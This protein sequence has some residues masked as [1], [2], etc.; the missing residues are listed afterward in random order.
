MW[1]IFI[2]NLD[3]AP[4]RMATSERLMTNAGLTFE[5][6]PACD[7]RSLEQ[8]D[9]KRLVS[10]H[11]PAFAKRPILPVEVACFMSHLAIWRRVASGDAQG[12]II[13]EDDFTLVP[14]LHEILS[15]ISSGEP[16]WDMLK[17][18]S[19]KKKHLKQPVTLLDDYRVGNV[20]KLPMSTLSYAITKPAAECLA[21][22]TIPFRRP[23]D[24]FVKHWW[25]HGLCVKVMMPPPVQRRSD[26]R[27]TSEIEFVRR[28][29]PQNNLLS[30][31]YKNALYH[32]AFKV[33]EVW[34]AGAQ[35]RHRR[36]H[37]RK[38]GEASGG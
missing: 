37:D 19:N 30:R 27:A 21:N 6:V 38:I 33:G 22:S 28:N 26:H 7:W 36:C 24:L 23:I 25:E 35:P 14:G 31:F 32:L 13:L 5:R 12:A 18:Y 9:L 20:D 8:A 34:N 16:D 1:P 3:R 11:P 10:P 29:M 4:E 15:R 2:I 17:L